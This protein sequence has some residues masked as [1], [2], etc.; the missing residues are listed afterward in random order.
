MTY[1]VSLQNTH[2]STSQAAYICTKLLFKKWCYIWNSKMSTNIVHA[3]DLIFIISKRDFMKIMTSYYQSLLSWQTK[4]SKILRQ[5]SIDAENLYT[6]NLCIYDNILQLK[7]SMR[8][9]RQLYILFRRL[10]LLLHYG[11]LLLFLL[12]FLLLIRLLCCC[13]TYIS[14][15]LMFFSPT[16]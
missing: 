11:R 13:Y 6:D 4:V 7:E 1:Y 16:H 15:C 5:T 2:K 8:Y 10:L 3:T 9:H 14:S 12:R